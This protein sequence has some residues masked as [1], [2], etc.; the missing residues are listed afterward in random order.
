MEQ[1]R[2]N[3]GK[4]LLAVIFIIVLAVGGFFAWKYVSG[5]ASPAPTPAT[6]APLMTLSET[7]S[8]RRDAT[9]PSGSQP[10]GSSPQPCTGSI[11]ECYWH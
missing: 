2:E 7:P 9:T 5:V 11:I 3:S 8:A 10:S 6:P 4:I 1:P